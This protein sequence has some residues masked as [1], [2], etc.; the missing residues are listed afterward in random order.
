MKNGPMV[1]DAEIVKENPE[2]DLINPRLKDSEGLGDNYGE[3][4]EDATLE[5][6]DDLFN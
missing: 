2:D 1:R 4:S 3:E 6:D 5:M